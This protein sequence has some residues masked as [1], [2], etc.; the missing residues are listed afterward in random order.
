MDSQP[1]IKR[2][3][4]IKIGTNSASATSMGIL[5]QLNIVIDRVSC[6]KLGHEWSVIKLCPI[7][8]HSTQSDCALYHQS[9]EIS[10]SRYG[11]QGPGQNVSVSRAVCGRVGSVT[12]GVDAEPMLASSLDRVAADVSSSKI[13]FRQIRQT[14]AVPG[15]RAIGTEA[16]SNDLGV[17]CM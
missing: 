16:E 5:C 10:A 2:W 12:W 14:H 17:V 13:M 1:F 3:T 7:R 8:F 11:L 6:Q 9:P 4:I 15:A